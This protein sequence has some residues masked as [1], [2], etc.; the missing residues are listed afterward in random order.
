MSTPTAPTPTLEEI[1][2]LVGGEV[3]GDP[4]HPVPGVSG[5]DGMVPGA[6]TFAENAR[7]VKEAEESEAGALLAPPG[8]E[9]RLPTVR[10]ANPRVAFAVLLDW[11]HP[12]IPAPRGI[13]PTATVDPS[14]RVDP[15]ASIGPLAVIGPGAQV[16]P[17][18]EVHARAVLGADCRVEAGTRIL[19]GAV[20]GQG[21]TVG[22][23]GLVGPLTS[24]AA[25]TV[26]GDDVEMGARCRLERCEVGPGCRLDNLVRVGQ[27]AR[28]GP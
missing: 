21:V 23:Q 6:M 5:L 27:G 12:R 26:V 2:R 9:S 15:E 17:G 18:C 19:P 13:H 28:L 11:F 14:A 16:G 4:G 8:T 3:H 20:L 10:V 24:L 25:G 7:A 22:R 1:A